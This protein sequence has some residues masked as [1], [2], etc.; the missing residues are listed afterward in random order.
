MRQSCARAK[1]LGG[2]DRGN[3]FLPWRVLL[4][5]HGVFLSLLIIAVLS[6]VCLHGA[7]S[8]TVVLRTV[9]GLFLRPARVCTPLQCVR[10]RSATARFAIRGAILGGARGL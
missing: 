2:R 6:R 8:S 7:R 3:S 1:V 4:Q 9:S 5:K 10:V